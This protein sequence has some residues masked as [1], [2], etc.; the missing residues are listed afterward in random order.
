MVK[1]D[2]Q[3]DGFWLGSLTK[4]LSFW[5]PD[6][7]ASQ[8]RFRNNLEPMPR[9]L[10]RH[11]V[12]ALTPHNSPTTLLP[13]KPF[14]KTR[15]I[16]DGTAATKLCTRRPPSNSWE[17]G[18]IKKSGE[19]MFENGYSDEFQS[20]LV[21]FQPSLVSFQSSLVSFQSLLVS[22]SFSSILIIVPKA[23]YKPKLLLLYLSKPDSSKFSSLRS[24]FL[25]FSGLRG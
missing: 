15:W 14:P 11:R 9:R 3:D 25:K 12:G 16:P 13:G 6:F 23:P 20:S 4:R 19:N 21:Q 2:P 1:D 10:S 17:F 5:K 22:F 8:Q 24:C 18:R 7:S